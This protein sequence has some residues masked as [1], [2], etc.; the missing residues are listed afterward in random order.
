MVVSASS[1]VGPTV[2]AG[3]LAVGPWQWLFGV[4]IPIGLAALVLGWRSAAANPLSGA[5]VRL[6]LGAC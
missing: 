4:N 5:P 3:I 6:D 2:A 1:A